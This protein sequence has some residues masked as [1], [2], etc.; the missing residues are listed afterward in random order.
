[1]DAQCDSHSARSVSI[2]RD[3][4]M[5]LVQ[6]YQGGKKKRGPHTH[7]Q[8]KKQQQKNKKQTN[9]QTKNNK[10]TKTKNNNNKNTFLER[11]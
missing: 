1:M 5:L 8:K 11:G 7:T 3:W 2:P 6:K 9:K 4:S 10:K